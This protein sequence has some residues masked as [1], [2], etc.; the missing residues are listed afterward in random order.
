MDTG[1]LNR[2][3]DR[4]EFF[5]G[6]DNV[7]KTLTFSDKHSLIFVDCHNLEFLVYGEPTNILFQNCANVSI[8]VTNVIA[9]I[10][11][12]RSNDIDIAIMDESE[13]PVT[14]Q[15]DIAYDVAISVEHPCLV[16]TI[17]C[18]D[19]LINE[20]VLTCS[21]FGDTNQFHLEK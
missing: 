16:Q 6:L 18:M 11:I 8:A 9:K 20:Q 1:F 14:I 13:T 7:K 2:I 3:Y 19:I 10:E 17:S 15:L 4:K 12:L 21:M 5:E